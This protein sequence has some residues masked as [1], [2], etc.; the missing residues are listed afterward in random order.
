MQ[1]PATKS[2]IVPRPATNV[3]ASPQSILAC[4]ILGV[5][6]TARDGWL[7]AAAASIA[8]TR[9]RALLGDASVRT[10]LPVELLGLQG[11]IDPDADP[12]VAPEARARSVD[13]ARR[14]GHAYLDGQ[15]SL[16]GTRFRV[17][18]T[19][20]RADGVMLGD[21]L[22]DGVSL[23]AA[24]RAA[25]APLV[26]RGALPTVRPPAA[27]LDYARARDAAELLQ[28]TDLAMAVVN[29]AADLEDQCAL[30][31]GASTDL[32]PFLLHICR[33][34]LGEKGVAGARVEPPAASTAG[35]RTARAR[36]RRLLRDTDPSATEQ[37]RRQYD[38]ERDP[39]VKSTIAA[40]LS[41]Q[42]Q[43]DAATSARDQAPTWAWQAVDDDPKNVHGEWC[44]PWGQLLSLVADTRDGGKATARWAAWTPWDSYAW[45]YLSK[46]AA[47]A[48]AATLVERAYALSPL[49]TNIAGRTAELRLEAGLTTQAE[50]VAQSLLSSSHVL[51]QVTGAQIAADVRAH[52]A[53]FKQ[54]LEVARAAMVPRSTDAGW[55]QSLRLAIAADAVTL[56]VLLGRPSEVA[57]AVIAAFTSQGGLPFA[58][59]AEHERRLIA[60]ICAYASPAGSAQCFEAMDGLRGGPTAQSAAFIAGARR[61]ALR[62]LTGAA[63][64]WRPLVRGA[65]EH[66]AVMPEAMVTAFAAAGELELAL[67]VDRRTRELAPLYGGATMAMARAA[68]AVAADGDPVE[69]SARAK[70][71]VDAWRFADEQPPIVRDL[72]R[73][74]R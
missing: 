67:E 59:S 7:G 35:G 55:T 25:M 33:Q 19:L 42:L 27:V 31:D 14:L 3:L 44:Y 41:C 50:A 9:A 16:V 8:C 48:R 37:L 11:L 63:A 20:R 15:V 18:L 28:L 32:A 46:R 66:L 36:V 47:P 38:A 45:W 43:V 39:G 60:S 72:R 61:Y 71:V 2:Q 68:L 6:N 13:A 30:L 51:H 56:A 21:G 58:G 74:V 26:E 5:E 57:D 34:Q 24:V 53:E 73:L 22:G 40:T 64:A 62:D 70:V 49:D 17:Q 1:R 29:H 12:F 4:P 10:L 52:D 65:D 23:P 69:A 54:A